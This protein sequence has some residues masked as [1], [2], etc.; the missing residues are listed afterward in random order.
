MLP[1]GNN[2]DEKAIERIVTIVTPQEAF[3]AAFSLHPAGV[4]VITGNLDD[5]TPAGFTATS[6]ASFSATPPRATVN[7]AQHASSYSAVTLGKTVILHFL[8]RHQVNISRTMAG[9]FSERFTGDHWAPG[10]G[11]L[12]QLHGVRA[13]LLATVVAVTEVGDNATIVFEINDGETHPDFP[14]LVYVD[15]RY[16]RVGDI[17]TN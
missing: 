14:P 11:G 1:F 9:D 13:A 15:R 4:A 7:I 2:D 10:L 17:V 3:L 16:H 8:S 5:G 12:P 6:L